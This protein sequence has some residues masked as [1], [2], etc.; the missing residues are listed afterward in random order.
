MSKLGSLVTNIFRDS[1][2]KV[3]NIFVVGFEE[4]SQPDSILADDF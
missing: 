2:E 4:V 1:S 3:E